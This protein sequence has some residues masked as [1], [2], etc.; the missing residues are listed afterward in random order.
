MIVT[1]KP[2][3]INLDLF[4]IQKYDEKL[5][6]KK[7]NKRCFIPL[8]SSHSNLSPWYCSFSS[9]VIRHLGINN[10]NNNDYKTLNAEVSFIKLKNSFRLRKDLKV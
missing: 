9:F 1:C 6:K 4:F 5:K 2:E 8:D 10:N 3:A 7:K